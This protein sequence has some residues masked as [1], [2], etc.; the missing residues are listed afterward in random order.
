MEN[1]KTAWKVSGGFYLQFEFYKL[2]AV[3]STAVSDIV[4]SII[5]VSD[6]VVVSVSEPSVLSVLQAATD[7]D[8]A[9]AKKPNLNRFFIMV[10]FKFDSNH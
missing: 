9:R 1:K 5:V 2:V 7:N 3:S 6:R 8:T 10:L 4:V